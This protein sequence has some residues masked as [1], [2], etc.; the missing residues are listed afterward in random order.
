MS[1]IQRRQKGY[2]GKTHKV[3]NKNDDG[4]PCPPDCEPCPRDCEPCPKDCEPCHKPCPRPCPRPCPKPCPDPCGPKVVDRDTKFKKDVIVAGCLRVYNK[5]TTDSNAS[6][7]CDLDV[8][9]NIVTNGKVVACGDITTKGKISAGDINANGKIN[10]CGNIHSNGEISACKDIATKGKI[11]ACGGIETQGNLDVKGD[12]QVQGNL[13]VAGSIR[14]NIIKVTNCTYTV[15]V[16]DFTVLLEGVK[17]VILPNSQHHV[18]QIIN[19]KNLSGESCVKV[20]GPLF[21]AKQRQLGPFC[22]I[23]LQSDG[24]LWYVLADNLVMF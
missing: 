5:L 20:K 18:G 11:V 19:L 10:A 14:A 1:G 4:E 21:H 7:A 6:I 16:N 9:G 23:Q 12:V 15:A 17:E 24:C 2:M 3:T 8:G 22:G 13:D